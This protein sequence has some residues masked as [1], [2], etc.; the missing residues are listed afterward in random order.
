MWVRNCL[1]VLYKV[2]NWPSSLHMG[3]QMWEFE[4]DADEKVLKFKESVS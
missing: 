3:V 4:E 2:D 1:K